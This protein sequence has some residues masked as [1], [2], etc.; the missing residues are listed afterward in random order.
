[1]E[2]T[3]IVVTRND[4]QCCIVVTTYNVDLRY[5]IQHRFTY[6]K[7]TVIDAT[8]NSSFIYHDYLT[9]IFTKNNDLMVINIPSRIQNIR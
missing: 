6:H 7:T 3:S 5:N 4:L 9:I 1:M 8:T 2:Q